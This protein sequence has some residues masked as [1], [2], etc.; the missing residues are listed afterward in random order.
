MKRVLY[1]PLILRLV[2]M[3][4]LVQHTL[5]IFGWGRCK[6]GGDA[7]DILALAFL[8]EALHSP[9]D[10]SAICPTLLD[11]LHLSHHRIY[12]DWSTDRS[13]QSDRASRDRADAYLQACFVGTTSLTVIV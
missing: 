11:S 3:R 4:L 2:K 6:Y 12:S 1:P 13:E 10:W 5:A 8:L 7:I 9:E